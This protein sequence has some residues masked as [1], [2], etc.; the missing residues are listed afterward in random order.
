VVEP[1]DDRSGDRGNDDPMGQRGPAKEI[2]HGA[3]FI[4][5]SGNRPFD[6]YR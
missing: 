2:P 4:A 5:E 1:A 6:S 3:Q